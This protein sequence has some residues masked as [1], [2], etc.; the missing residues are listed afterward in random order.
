[1]SLWLSMILCQLGGLEDIM[2]NDM[3]SSYNTLLVFNLKYSVWSVEM[4]CQM[5]INFS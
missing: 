3:L 2:Q 4:S 5:Q 1:M